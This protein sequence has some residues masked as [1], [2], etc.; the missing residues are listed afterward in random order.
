MI[1]HFGPKIRIIHPGLPGEVVE[2]DCEVQIWDAPCNR[3]FPLIPE[4]PWN[5]AVRKAQMCRTALLEGENLPEEI[6]LGF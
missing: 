4:F 2:A 5:E 3:W 1:T 6:N